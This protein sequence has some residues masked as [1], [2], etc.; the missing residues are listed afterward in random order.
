MATRRLHTPAPQPHRPATR[1][2]TAQCHQLRPRSTALP[3]QPRNHDPAQPRTKRRQRRTRN[4]AN[5]PKRISQRRPTPPRTRPTHIPHRPIPRTQPTNR[6]DRDRTNTHGTPPHERKNHPD[7]TAAGRQS[8]PP[9]VKGFLN[10]GQLQPPDVLVVFQVARSTLKSGA[11]HIGYQARP[12]LNTNPAAA[13]SG[14]GGPGQRG[15]G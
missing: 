9:D 7:Q 6:H 15:A 8:A 2:N 1:N 13:S 4:T 11:T 14:A 12:T 3:P 10:T 5:R